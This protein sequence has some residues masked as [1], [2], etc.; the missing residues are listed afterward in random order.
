MPCGVWMSSGGAT[1][2]RIY[3]SDAVNGSY[4]DVR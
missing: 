1:L 2:R 4:H 3:L